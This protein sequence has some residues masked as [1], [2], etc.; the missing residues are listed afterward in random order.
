MRPKLC[1]RGNSLC[2]VGQGQ[3]EARIVERRRPQS[4]H[5]STKTV[6]CA[7][8]VRRTAGEPGEC[9]AVTKT[10]SGHRQPQSG[11]IAQNGTTGRSAP[12][13]LELGQVDL[14]AIEDL[15]DR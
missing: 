4:S 12:Q 3:V 6:R 10:A 2:H 15:F 9:V 7:V 14:A 5:W 1:S 8:T 11:D 13:N